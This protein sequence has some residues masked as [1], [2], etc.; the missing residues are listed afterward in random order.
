[1]VEKSVFHC[2]MSD[3]NGVVMNLQVVDNYMQRG[4]IEANP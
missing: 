2:L 3:P 1:M 4:W